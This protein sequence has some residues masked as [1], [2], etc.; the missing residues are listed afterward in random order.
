MSE[1]HDKLKEAEIL[2]S[3]LIPSKTKDV[4]SMWAIKRSA[5]WEVRLMS[6]GTDLGRRCVFWVS[7]RGAESL[8][9]GA[10]P[11]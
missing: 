6:A 4:A 3:V 1:S 5:M 2:R 8:L 7:E 9:A 11:F 10:L